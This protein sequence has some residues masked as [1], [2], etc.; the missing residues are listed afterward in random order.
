MVTLF[1]YG[2]ADFRKQE[3]PAY[4]VFMNILRNVTKLYFKRRLSIDTNVS[5]I[6]PTKFGEGVMC[7]LYRILMA[8][9][10]QIYLVIS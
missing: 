4:A 5:V 2:V 1:H 8:I 6:G 3:K 9:I 7:L 10:T